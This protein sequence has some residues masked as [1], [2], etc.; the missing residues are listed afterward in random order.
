[1]VNPT[2]IAGGVGR[3]AG[4]YVSWVEGHRSKPTIIEMTVQTLSEQDVGKFR[5]S[6]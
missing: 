5:I 2:E 4:R 1:M 3:E 6:V